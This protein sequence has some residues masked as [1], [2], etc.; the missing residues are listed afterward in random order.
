[1]T[2]TEIT[3]ALGFASM[4]ALVALAAPIRETPKDAPP[5][6]DLR[7]MTN[8]GKVEQSD[9]AVRINADGTGSGWQAEGV[10]DGGYLHVGWL[11]GDRPAWGRYKI[12][13]RTLRGEWG[14]LA[15]GDR[16]AETIEIRDGE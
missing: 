16:F 15:G 8:W 14:W 5:P 9:L 4:L 6:H 12:G 2:K 7:G 3:V 1:M 11:N 13:Q 10:I